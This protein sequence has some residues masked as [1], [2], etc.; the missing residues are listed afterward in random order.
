MV[1]TTRTL[2][3]PFAAVALML[4]GATRVRAQ[5]YDSPVAYVPAPQVSYYT[6]AVSYYAPATSYYYAPTVAYYAPAVSYSA[7]A[8]SY[9]APAVSYYAP[10]PSY[11]AAPGA[12]TTT[13]YGLFGRPRETVTRYYP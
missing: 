1:R 11:Y 8:V 2:T 12:V 7:P 3:V 9:Y 6:P 10:T 13:Y 4:V 5:C